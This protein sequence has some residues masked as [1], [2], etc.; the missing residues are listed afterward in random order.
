MF[1]Q[2]F[3]AIV[4]NLIILLLESV[5]LNFF[6]N[7]FRSFNVIWKN[8]F[9]IIFIFTEVS[10]EIWD[11]FNSKMVFKNFSDRRSAIFYCF[12]IN[13]YG[14][15]YVLSISNLDQNQCLGVLGSKISNFYWFFALHY[16]DF[17]IAVLVYYSANSIGEVQYG[18]PDSKTGFRKRSQ[19][20]Q[21][22]YSGK[23]HN[24][25]VD[26]YITQYGWLNRSRFYCWFSI[27]NYNKH[28]NVDKIKLLWFGP[29]FKHDGFNITN[30]IKRLNIS[31]FSDLFQ[32]QYSGIFGV[33]DQEFSFCFHQK[34]KLVTGILIFQYSGSLEMIIFLM[35]EVRFGLLIIMFT[36]SLI[37]PWIEINY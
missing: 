4:V 32:L 11:V 30:P 33:V 9:F 3:L 26:F 22:R 15:L 2:N 27:I 25:F 1:S 14:G 35:K 23:D 18:G 31:I 37:L 34:S 6:N 29:K 8:D 19:F 10:L 24:F 7:L 28:N 36:V 20:F 21:N 12:C 5:T 17:N 13:Q 16:G